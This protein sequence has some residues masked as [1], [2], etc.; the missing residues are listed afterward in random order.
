MRAGSAAKRVKATDG[1][2]FTRIAIGVLNPCPSVC[3]R[4][5]PWL[6]FFR[7]LRSPNSLV[8]TSPI[9]AH[10]AHS[11]GNQSPYRVYSVCSAT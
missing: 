11:S 3:I 4:V 5:H 6:T 2:G 1:H 7:Q 10:I 9:T 8:A